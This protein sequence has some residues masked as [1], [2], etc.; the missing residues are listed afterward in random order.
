MIKIKLVQGTIVAG[1]ASAN[2]QSTLFTPIYEYNS[3]YF[4]IKNM[5]PI[6]TGYNF[7]ITFR[8]NKNSVT[9]L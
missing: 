8:I 6:Q 2:F 5:G 9:T 1:T 7:S 4:T 3:A